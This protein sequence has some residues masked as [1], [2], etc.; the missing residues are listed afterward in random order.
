MTVATAHDAWLDAFGRLSEERTDPAWLTEMRRKAMHRFMA[1]GFPTPRDEDWIYTNLSALAGR[2]FHRARATP[3]PMPETLGGHHLDAVTGPRLVFVN[4]HYD[5]ALSTLDALPEGVSLRT[6]ASI[7][8]ASPDALADAMARLTGDTAHAFADLGT[9]FFEDGAV[10]EVAAG[11]K[12]EA[13]IQI[14]FLMKSWA[15]D[16]VEHP[17]LIV[18]AGEGSDFTLLERYEA[19]GPGQRF[20]NTAALVDLA[21]SARVRHVR[22]QREGKSAFHIGRTLVT[23]G[24]DSTYDAVSV[25]LGGAICRHEIDADLQAAGATCLLGGLSV[26]GGK[27][28]VDNHTIVHHSVPHGTSHELYKNILGGKARGAFTG[29]MVVHAD[30]QHTSSTQANHNLLLSDEAIAETRPQLEI[31]ADDVQCAHGATIGQLDD[32]QLFYLRSRGLAPIA[33]RNLLIHGF[34]SEVIDRVADDDVR[35]LLANVLES[36]LNVDTA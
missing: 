19:Q 2:T 18:R 23:Q 29:K 20:T 7:L 13:P 31:Y 9:A 16:V 26:L 32:D 35:A 10:L 22:L 30:A 33:A 15:N 3:T 36:R 8:E 14:V 34:A 11:T 24:R 17:R 21:P 1:H 27:E 6:V 28:H 4:G 12:V 5:A 25:S